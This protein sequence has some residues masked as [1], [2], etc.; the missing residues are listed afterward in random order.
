MEKGRPAAFS[1]SLVQLERTMQQSQLLEE[2]TT[3]S[4]ID[5]GWAH[6]P[7]QI[8]VLQ[9]PSEVTKQGDCPLAFAIYLSSDS[10]STEV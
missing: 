4:S 7:E 5:L 2:R 9:Q 1:Q 3:L 6:P 10:G 8:T